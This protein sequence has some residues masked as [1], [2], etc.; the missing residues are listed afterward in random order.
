MIHLPLNTCTVR[1]LQHGDAESIAH[2]GNNHKIANKMRNVFPSPYTIDHAHAWINMNLMPENKNWVNA[3]EVEGKAVGVASVLFKDDIYK[4]SAEVGYWIGEPFWNK[5]IITEA[6]KALTEYTLQNTDLKRLYAEVFDNNKA[7]ARVLQ[8]AG[9][10]Y[11]CTHKK[12]IIKNGEI[13][14]SHIYTIIR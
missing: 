12:S 13:V 2:F 1:T 10:T 8:K 3:V 5:G 6:V 7:S 9:F 14:D 11:E 4:H